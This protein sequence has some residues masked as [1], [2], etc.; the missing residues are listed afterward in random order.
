MEYGFAILKVLKHSG[1]I[2]V[3]LVQDSKA[4][5][6][7]ANALRSTKICLMLASCEKNLKQHINSKVGK[8]FAYL[9]GFLWNTVKHM[10]KQKIDF[11]VSNPTRYRHGIM[12]EFDTRLRNKSLVTGS[13]STFESNCASTLMYNSNLKSMSSR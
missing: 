6:G 9:S 11:S 4:D 5:K 3:S 12:I 13:T 2:F 1:K 7:T 10:A 8:V